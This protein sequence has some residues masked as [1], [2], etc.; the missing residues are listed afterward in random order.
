[1]KLNIIFC[2]LILALSI[3]SCNNSEEKDAVSPSAGIVDYYKLKEGINTWQLLKSDKDSLDK[4]SQ[5]LGDLIFGQMPQVISDTSFLNYITEI[6]YAKINVPKDKI[7]KM[8]EAFLISGTKDLPPD[9]VCIYEYRDIL[10][11]RNKNGIIGIVKICFSC[12]DVLIVEAE[13]NT[14]DMNWSF[15]EIKELLHSL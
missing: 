8:K 4:S 13:E 7:Q 1:M 10:I 2:F 12:E 14:L 9:E 5:L 3:L 15:S 11:L 6:G